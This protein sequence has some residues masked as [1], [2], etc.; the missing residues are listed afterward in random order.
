MTVARLAKAFLVSKS[1]NCWGMITAI[2]ISFPAGLAKS[3]HAVTG[4]E[5]LDDEPGLAQHLGDTVALRGATPVHLGQSLRVNAPRQLL[6]Q[7]PGHPRD[8]LDQLGND[9]LEAV[10]FTVEQKDLAALAT[11][12]AKVLDLFGSD[13]LQRRGLGSRGPSCSPPGRH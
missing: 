8:C 6:G 4:S 5:H 1:R 7:G 11:S 12:G 10:A 9:I 3:R 2:G 13:L